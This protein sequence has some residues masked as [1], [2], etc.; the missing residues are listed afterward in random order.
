MTAANVTDFK[1]AEKKRDSNPEYTAYRQ[2]DRWK[3]LSRAVSMRAKGKCEICRRRDGAH[4][5]HLVYDHMFNEPMSD[6]LW[7][8]KSCHWKLD[9]PRGN[10]Q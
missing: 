8:C 7:L 3:K 2:S 4:C 6:L 1:P 5:A 9:R 10:P